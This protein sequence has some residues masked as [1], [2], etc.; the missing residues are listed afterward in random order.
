MK[1]NNTKHFIKHTTDNCE[2]LARYVVDI[3]DLEDLISCMVDQITASYMDD[4]V[5]FQ[6]N[7]LDYDITTID[8]L[9]Q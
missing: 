9:K 4:A 6:Q 3:M 2:Y 8:E 7:L 1:I 5:L